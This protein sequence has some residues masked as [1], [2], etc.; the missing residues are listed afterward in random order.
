MFTAIKKIMPLSPLYPPIEPYDTGML[1]VGDGHNL[2]WEQSGNP[3]GEPIVFL[4]GGPGSGTSPAH[5]Q[6]FDPAKYRIILFDQ[7]G[8]GK[9]TPHAS[10]DNN[11][12]PHLVADIEK[13][14]AHLG[15]ENWHVFGGSW[16]S[17]LGLAYAMAHSERVD[18]LVL[19]G[20]FL[21]R[22]EELRNLYFEGGVVSRVF[23]DVFEDFIKLLPEDKRDN[24]LQGYYELFESE[25]RNM[26]LKALD[27]WTRLE[28]RVASLVVTLGALNKEM[29]NPDFVLAHS[30]LEN[31]YF[32]HNGFID[33]NKMLENLS[34]IIGDKT[35][36]LVQGRYDMVCLF[37][38]AWEV[39]QSLPNSQIHIIEDAGHTKKQPQVARKLI[40]ILDAL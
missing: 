6:F 39:H 1:D 31:H 21:C 2:Y 22:E 13:L 23:P 24:P 36:H 37:K 33:G 34:K 30:L 3:Q 14:R 5:R 8:A 12:T 19:Y 9:S 17:T 27:L 18:A 16:G 25:D 28:K 40:E 4:H 7:R 26:R 29:A 32:K 15:L 38:T 20:I 35:I 11:T 10:L